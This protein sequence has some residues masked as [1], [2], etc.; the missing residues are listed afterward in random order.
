MKPLDL[1]P[2]V[3]QYDRTPT[4]TFCAKHLTRSC[5]CIPETVTTTVPLVPDVPDVPHLPE[6]TGN[7]LAEILN[8][9]RVRD[10]VKP[11]DQAVSQWLQVE[12]PTPEDMQDPPESPAYPYLGRVYSLEEIKHLPP[13]KPLVKGWLSTPSAAV[14]VGAYGIGKSALTLTMACSLASGTPF[15]GIEV[16]RTRVLYL[17][18]EGVRGLPLR[19]EAWQ[20]CWGKTL[21]EGSLVFMTRQAG[22]LKDRHT[23]RDLAGYCLDNAVGLVVLDTLSSLA[24]DADETKDAPVIVSGLNYLA[25]QING[26][27]LLVHHPG[28]SAAD[29]TRGG[30]QFEGNVDEVL[31]LSSASEGS[32]HLA[33]KV[34]KAKD[35]ES[36]H[37]HYLRRIVVDLARKDEDGRD[38]RSVTVEGARLADTAVPVKARIVAYL[39]ACGNIGATAKEIAQEV[40]ATP[41]SGGF[42][43]ALREL[44][45]D[46][47]TTTDGAKRSTRYYLTDQS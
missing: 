8:E 35:G 30:Y 44:V 38:L 14:L 42:R 1:M 37:T 29:R 17:V 12:P 27:A 20:K 16:E 3:P 46:R 4:V 5:T 43:L 6:P 25:E 47:Q 10:K 24:A 40:G 19:V 45:Q 15:L 18:G 21:P 22:S 36:G 32:E 26:T 34:K 7:R 2:T 39:E 41:S 13:I 33:V 9:V 23:W 31:L 11:T 28:W